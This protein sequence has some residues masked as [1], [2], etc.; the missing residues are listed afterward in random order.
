MNQQMTKWSTF[1]TFI[2][3]KI[4]LSDIRISSLAT[5]EYVEIAKSY[6]MPSCVTQRS[7]QSEQVIATPFF[8]F[9]SQYKVWHQIM[10]LISLFGVQWSLRSIHKKK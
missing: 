2:S 8:F 1:R 10:R 4:F 6:L 3:F 9:F 5:E 7:E